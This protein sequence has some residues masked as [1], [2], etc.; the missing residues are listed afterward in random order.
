MKYDIKENERYKVLMSENYNYT[1]DK[2]EGIFIRYGKTVKD[3]PDMSP[4][5]PEIADIEVTTQCSGVGGKLC[6]FCYKSN[7]MNGKNM[8]IDTF[9]KLFDNLPKTLTQIAFGVDSKC[10]SNKDIWDMMKYSRQHGIASNVTVADVSDDV[11]DKLVEHCSAVAVSRYENKNFCYDSVKKLTD[12]GM[13]Q[14]NIHIMLSADT[15]D[16]V[17]ETIKDYSTDERLAKLNAIVILNLKTKGRGVNHKI[18]PQPEFDKLVNY[19]MSNNV[20]IGFDSCGA[21]KFLETIKDRENRE[22]MEMYVEPCESGLFSFYSNVD[23]HF[24]PCSFSEGEKD[25]KTG[26]DCTVEGMDF[27][28]DLW[29]HEKTVKW[30]NNLLKCGRNCPL[31]N[32]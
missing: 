32:I 1:F 5:G 6:D 2:N 18:L 23:G 3:D 26:I 24:F 12:R 8:S 4:F 28:K 31:F 19:A 29:F 27:L 9:K 16:L 25:W 30:R 7:N 15:V 20:P 11:A 10:D 21:N 22:Q 17:W 13:G 14:V